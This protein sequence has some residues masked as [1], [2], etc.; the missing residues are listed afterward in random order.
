MI[1]EITTKEYTLDASGKSVGRIS[2]EIAK[3]LLG[4]NT[5]AFA[6]NITQDVK[7]KV[8]NASKV[9]ITGNKLKDSTHKNYSLYPGGLKIKSWDVVSKDKGF[10]EIIKHAVKGMLPRNKLQ[11][12]RFLN[13]SITE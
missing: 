2:T 9:K 6:K 4:K 13:L 3:I 8:I 1:K 10:G 11:T 5:P 12:K 7:V